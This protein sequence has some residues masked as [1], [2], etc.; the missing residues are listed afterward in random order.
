MQ[1]LAIILILSTNS[2]AQNAILGK[3]ITIDDSSGEPRSIVEITERGSIISG[4]KVKLFPSPGEE[5]DP[6]CD[7]CPEDDE[8]YKKKII[9]LDIIRNMKWSKDELKEGNILDPESGK[10]YKCIIWVEGGK[11]MVRGYW[12]PFYRTQ[13]WKKAI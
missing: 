8:R 12:G 10:I 13:I 2:F 3:W 1:I 4:K 7:K 11:L 6:I 9:G 5:P